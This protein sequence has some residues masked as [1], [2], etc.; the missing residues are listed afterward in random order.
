MGRQ[1]LLK[2]AR[3]LE[4]RGRRKCSPANTQPAFCRAYRQEDV[5]AVQQMRCLVLL[6]PTQLEL[7]S[8]ALPLPL[9]RKGLAGCVV[10]TEAST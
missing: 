3:H 10:P 4:R 8:Q 1:S 5:C 2:E 9:L 7:C 6:T